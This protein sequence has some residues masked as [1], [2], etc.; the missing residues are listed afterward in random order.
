LALSEARYHEIADGAP[1]AA[2]LSRAD[3]ALIYINRALVET[4]GRPRMELLG[5]GWIDAIDPED[6]P[7]FLAVRERA[8]EAHGSVQ[9][10]GHFRRP[11]GA[12]RTVELF[13]RPRFDFM[14]G[15]CGH[16]GLARD[17]TAI[18]EADAQRTVLVNELNHRVRNTLATVQSLVRH[19]LREHGAPGEAERA[20]VE[21]VMALSAAH[22]VLSRESWTGAALG[23][24]VQESLSVHDTSGRIAAAGPS[25]RISPKSA[26]A[27]ALAL[28][29]L[30]ANASTHGALS[31]PEGRVELSWKVN[32]DKVAL[33]WR[34]IGGPPASSPAASGFAAFLL[35][36]MLA[37]D[38]GEAAQMI[39][40]PEGLICRIRAPVMRA[41]TDSFGNSLNA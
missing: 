28:Q 40:A 13:G 37:A 5:H 31:A 25:V 4:L 17:V 41:C 32:E 21:R 39:E 26:I 36:R 23:D 15:F 30:A 38:L 35:G 29:E 22:N 9:Y 20:V 12:L 8:R 11:D 1:A 24:L 14:G 19:T 7:E 2:W 16:V 34:E 27:L 33:E 10:E 3:G 6:R 18:R